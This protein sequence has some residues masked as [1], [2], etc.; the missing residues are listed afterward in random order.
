MKFSAYF[1]LFPELES[2]YYL[3]YKC[4]TSEFW[5]AMKL[6]QE[7]YEKEHILS[8]ANNILIKREYQKS[9][10]TFT[11]MNKVNIY[12]YSTISRK[13]SFISLDT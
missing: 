2:Q 4:G 3:K 6:G 9:Q 11:K 10:N 8:N 13:K 12:F 7:N 1:C 5:V